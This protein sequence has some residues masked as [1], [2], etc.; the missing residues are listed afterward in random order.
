VEEA[1]QHSAVKD[2]SFTP[3][4]IGLAVFGGLGILGVVAG[5]VGYF[6]IGGRGIVLGLLAFTLSRVVMRFWQITRTESFPR[7]RASSS[8]TMAFAIMWAFLSTL[9]IVVLWAML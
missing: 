6:F 7:N 4:E 3:G 8:I 2:D 1:R 9:L 5:V